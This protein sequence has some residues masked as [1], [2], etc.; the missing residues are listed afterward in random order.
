MVAFTMCVASN[1]QSTTDTTKKSKFEFNSEFTLASRGYARGVGFGESPSLQGLICVSRYGFELGTYGGVTA[2]GNRS[3]YGNW[4]ENYLT[5]KYKN[6]SLTIDDYFFYNSQDTLNNFF[7]Y[8]SASTNHF[9]EARAKYEYKKIQLMAGYVIYSCD[10]DT[11]TGVYAEATYNVGNGTSF[12]A[13][14]MTA[15]SMLNFIDAAGFT[16]IG[17]YH[18][19]KLKI[20]DETTA[21]IK[22]T[23]AFNPSYKSIP[24]LPGVG[25]NPVNLIF[26]I[27]F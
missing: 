12:F 21:I 2:T 23:L 15:P 8:N 9:V 26:A 11:T 20:S 5:Y 14:Y 25:R 18:K 19:R 7:D 24:Q 6:L 1:A 27:T 13:G 10:F 22:T 4:V 3:G 16:N 17:I